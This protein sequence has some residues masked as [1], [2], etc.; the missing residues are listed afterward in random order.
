MATVRAEMI[1]TD[2]LDACDATR[3]LLASSSV[4]EQWEGPSALEHMSVGALAGHLMRAVTSVDA[5]LDKPVT[6]VGAV[7]DAPGYYASIEG[8]VGD[9][10]ESDLHSA[11]RRRAE[12]GAEAGHA[13]VVQR[14][15][16]VL[17]RLRHRLPTEPPHRRLPA[18][19]ERLISL[20]DYLITRLVELIVHSEDLAVSVGTTPPA[21]SREATGAVIECLVGVARVRHGDEAV[22]TALS[23]RERDTVNALRVL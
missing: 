19:G 20:N 15:D 18:L 14:W 11:I 16:E 6:D 4:A 1:R 13:G 2:F 17:E 5:Y 12:A 7:L 22:I 23:R 21:F 10:L 3:P 9:D 8:L